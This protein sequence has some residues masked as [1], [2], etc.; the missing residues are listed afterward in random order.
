MLNCPNEFGI[1][2]S[3]IEL[4]FPDHML[5]ENGG[6]YTNKV[7]CQVDCC[8]VNEIKQLWENG[9]VTTGSCCGHGL[10]QG[11]INV[12]ESSVDLMF[13]LGYE[14]IDVPKGCWEHSFIPKTNHNK[15]SYK[16]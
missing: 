10:I 12:T 1:Y 15:D 2:D 6:Y 9:V 16:Q 14:L 3:M 13:K 7:G 8:L 11:M 4:R 5:K